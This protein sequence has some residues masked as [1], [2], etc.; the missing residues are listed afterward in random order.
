MGQQPCRI[1][2]AGCFVDEGHRHTGKGAN[3][4]TWRDFGKLFALALKL[5]IE[6][7]SI[8]L[9]PWFHPIFVSEHKLTSIIEYTVLTND[10]LLWKYNHYLGIL[11]QT[12]LSLSHTLSSKRH[13]LLC[14]W[15]HCKQPLPPWLQLSCFL[16][17]GNW[18]TLFVWLC[19]LM[20]PSHHLKQCWP[21]INEIQ[22]YSSEG[23]SWEITR[24]SII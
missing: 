21:I 15:C 3:L 16:S 19:C 2:L 8:M 5:D 9:N 1:L 6:Q 11:W 23:I 18:C 12:H 10:I 13:A 4:T 14:A 20:A 17:S 24:P 22:W 7:P